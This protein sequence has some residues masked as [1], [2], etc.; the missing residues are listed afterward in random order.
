MALVIKQ[1]VT[2]PDGRKVEFSRR[3]I[4]LSADRSLTGCSRGAW[5]KGLIQAWEAAGRFWHQ[6]I[7]PKKFTHAGATEYG[8]QGRTPQYTRRKLRKFGH[9]YPL[10]YTGELKRQALRTEDI[11]STARGVKIVIHGPAYLYMYRRYQPQK[12]SA[13]ALRRAQRRGLD[14]SRTID[15]PDK[16]GELQAVSA[17]DAELIAKKIDRFLAV[18]FGGPGDWNAARGHA[19]GASALGQGHREMPGA[20]G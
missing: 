1:T 13:A 15:Q 16:A 18:K 20:A 14:T 12:L 11:R 2:M 7:L 9:T 19:G 4:E 5:N 17:R 10:V 3:G 6:E 8:Y